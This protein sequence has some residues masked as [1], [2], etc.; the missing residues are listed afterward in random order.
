[1][2]SCGTSGENCVEGRCRC[3]DDKKQTT[4]GTRKQSS[5]SRLWRFIEV[6]KTLVTMGGAIHAHSQ[7]VQSTH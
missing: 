4:S 3:Y 2:S 1:M 6:S 5:N 7:H